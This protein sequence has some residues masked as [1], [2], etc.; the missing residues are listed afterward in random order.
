MTARGDEGRRGPFRC[1]IAGAAGTF[2]DP[3]CGGI[4]IVLGATIALGGVALAGR[5]PGIRVQTSLPSMRSPPVHTPM[6]VPRLVRKKFSSTRATRFLHQ[7]LT[8]LTSSRRA[9]KSA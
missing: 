1:S 5:G 4:E 8:V 3:A 7:P 2:R 9:R 6:A